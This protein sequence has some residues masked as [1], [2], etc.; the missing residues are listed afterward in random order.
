MANT[1]DA[2]YER[3]M[4]LLAFVDPEGFNDRQQAQYTGADLDSCDEGIAECEGMLAWALETGNREEIK[5][6]KR[7][8]QQAKTEKRRIRKM[9]EEQSDERMFLTA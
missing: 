7:Y 9:I 3:D 8:L 4:F 2:V 6:W 5:A 1:S